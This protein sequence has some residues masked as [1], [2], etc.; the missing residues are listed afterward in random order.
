MLYSLNT[1]HMAISL[2]AQVYS[3][4]L[5]HLVA[6]NMMV[7]MWHYEQSAFLWIIVSQVGEN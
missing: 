3:F 5:V 6:F 7:L 1:L 4:Y 2:S